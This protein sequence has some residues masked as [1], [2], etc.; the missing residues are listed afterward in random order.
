MTIARRRRLIKR[1]RTGTALAIAATISFLAG[2][3]DAIGLLS[4]GDFVSFMSGNTTRAAIALGEGNFTGALLLV[5]ALGAF[6]IGNALGVIVAARLG[7]V[8]VLS[9]VSLVL[10]LCAG[11]GPLMPRP[12]YFYGV[13]LSMGLV[14]A[15]VEHIEGLPIGLTYVTGALSRFGRG[16]GRWLLGN[17]NRQWFV[18]IVPWLGMF[19]GAVAGALL[20]HHFS[21]AALW[22]SFALSTGLALATVLVPSHWSRRYIHSG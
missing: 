15:A 22:A 1:Q 9:T 8:G 16:L 6:I 18:Q 12:F 5:G 19:S 17:K 20:E 21:T 2:M 3:T 7:V 14:N 11:F 10:M 4:I 13:V